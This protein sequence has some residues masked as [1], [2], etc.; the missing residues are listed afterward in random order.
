[1]INTKSA[2][3]QLFSIAGQKIFS[4]NIDSNNDNQRFYIPGL[5]SGIYIV[6][7]FID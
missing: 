1:M 7:L 6:K 4:K 2:V 5:N 3:L